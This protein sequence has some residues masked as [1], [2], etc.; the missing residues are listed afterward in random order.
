VAPLIINSR[1]NNILPHPAP[2]HI[3]EVLPCGKP[4]SVISSR[5]GIPEG[6]FS[7]VAISLKVWL[8]SQVYSYIIT[9]NYKYFPLYFSAGK[10]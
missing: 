9:K 7:N 3:S 2:P 6:V 10:K 5:P 1:E 4:P 8:Y